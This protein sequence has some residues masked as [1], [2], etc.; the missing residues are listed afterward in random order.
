[1][2]Y[3]SLSPR[4]LIA[5]RVTSL[6]H[7]HRLLRFPILSRGRFDE[8]ENIVGFEFPAREEAV[9]RVLFHLEN[10]ES[11][12][13]LRVY[14]QFDMRLMQIEECEIAAGLPQL[15]ACKDQRGKTRRIKFTQIVEIQCNT[16][17]P[18]LKEQVQ[19]MAKIQIVLPEC[20]RPFQVHDL[21]PFLLSMERL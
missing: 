20:E 21:D 5:G 6:D 14:Q 15:L 11:R 2:F 13:Q 7:R 4:N 16:G 19:F 12:F 3:V 18:R 1:M 10:F 17:I 8:L 9:D